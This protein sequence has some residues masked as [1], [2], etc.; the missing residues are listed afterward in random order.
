MHLR[1]YCSLTFIH[2]DDCSQVMRE[3][4]SESVG[5]PP[6]SRI[7]PISRGSYDRLKEFYAPVRTDCWPRGLRKGGHEKDIQ[8]RDYIPGFRICRAYREIFSC[9]LPGSCG[10]QCLGDFMYTEGCIALLKPFSDNTSLPPPSSLTI[11]RTQ[12]PPSPS[13]TAPFYIL[14]YACIY[15]HGHPVHII[16]KQTLYI[17]FSIGLRSDVSVGVLQ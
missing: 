3:A 9:T 13:S 4:F 7:K 11:S 10:S 8:Q 14:H 16:R 15:S 17:V 5:D 1:E 6:S 2:S 12:T